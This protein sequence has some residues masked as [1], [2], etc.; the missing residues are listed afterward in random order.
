[1][2]VIGHRGAAALA[3]ENTWEG[4]DVAL[5]LGV[6]AIETDVQVSRD[7]ELILIHDETLDRTTNGEG[8]IA[9]T[10]WS[11]IKT[12][13]AG[14]WFSKRYQGARI[15]R[16][17][18]TLER[19]GERVHLVLEVKVLGIEDQV[20]GMVRELGL[21]DNVTFTS[22]FFEVAQGIKRANAHAKVGFLT[23][24][25]SE[26]EVMRV[27]STDLDQFC[28][29][30]RA[31]LGEQVSRWKALGLEVRAWGVTDTEVMMNAIHAG[32]DGM[33]VDFPHLLLEALGR[34]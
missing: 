18:D 20:L 31:V 4:F 14:S 3:P 24:D 17:Y 28:P 30:A 23:S 27:V 7:G 5:S 11:A 19:Y 26:D 9:D 6:D 25:T 29:P 8:R 1:M 21:I 12:L 15:P 22:T 13:D 10:P 32:V 2:Q 16:L 34:G 33:T